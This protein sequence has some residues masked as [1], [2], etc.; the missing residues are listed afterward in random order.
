MR[1]FDTSY[2]EVGS[3]MSE[4]CQLSV[5]GPQLCNIRHNVKTESPS[6]AWIR[7]AVEPGDL[8]VIPAGIYHRFTLDEANNIKAT[9]LFK[10]SRTDYRR[11]PSVSSLNLITGRA[12]MDPVQPR[13]GDRPQPLPSPVPA[14]H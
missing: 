10:V 11:D 7:L 8:I 13:R 6:D 14:V 4:V 1:K 3:S 2:R 12:K 9:R 5:T